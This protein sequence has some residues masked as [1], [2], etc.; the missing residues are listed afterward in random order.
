MVEERVAGELAAVH[1][2]AVNEAM[3]LMHLQRAPLARLTRVDLARRLHV[4]PS[5]VTRMT[6]PLEKRGLV[7]RQPDPHD[8]RLAYVSI[9]EAG[10]AV[11]VSVR[12]TL[13][14]RSAEFFRDRWTSEEIETLMELLGRLSS[15]E[16]GEIV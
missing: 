11:I 10:L 13:E 1:G 12:E 9:S 7:E 6:T 5:T 2:L 15:N 16:I 8:A 4:N 14:R 3:L